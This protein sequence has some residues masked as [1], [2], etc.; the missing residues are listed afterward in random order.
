MFR[1]TLIASLLSA[2]IGLGLV[3]CAASPVL[4]TAPAAQTTAAAM[5]VQ[6]S[7]ALKQRADQLV[8]LLNGT[9]QPSQIFASEA[10]AKVPAERWTGIATAVRERRGKAM[11][12][13]RI[14][15]E[16]PHKGTVVIDFAE[17]Q[18]SVRIRVQSEAPHQVDGLM[19]N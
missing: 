9:V 4:A 14:V 16:T 6:P 15:A 13:S 7:E 19:L 5:V 12:V 2:T 1:D 10:L 8:G 11:G 18:F 17:S 3:G